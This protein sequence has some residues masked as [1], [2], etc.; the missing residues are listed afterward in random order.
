MRKQPPISFP[1]NASLRLSSEI[2]N[3]A[4][5]GNLKPPC[6]KV[7]IQMCW[8]CVCSAMSI[9]IPCFLKL[10]SRSWELFFGRSS[11]SLQVKRGQ[12]EPPQASSGWEQRKKTAAGDRRISYTPTCP[13]S[14]YQHILLLG[15]QLNTHWNQPSGLFSENSLGFNHVPMWVRHLLNV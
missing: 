8:L 10:F 11:H 12:A 3:V 4:W 14:I 2:S 9:F 6:R 5:H 1:M 7:I 15:L 13:F